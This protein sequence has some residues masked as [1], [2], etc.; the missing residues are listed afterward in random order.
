MTIRAQTNGLTAV[1]SMAGSMSARDFGDLHRELIG[2]LKMRRKR[3]VLDFGGVDH[4]S[5]RDAG[6]LAREFEL[7]RSHNGDLKVAG[8]SPYV[9]NIL[10]FAGLYGFL[11]RSAQ[12][13]EFLEGTEHAHVLRAS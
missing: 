6:S 12:D 10:L 5:Y 7:V 13:G 9:R 3:I 1:L 8:L 11:E 4:I 2:L